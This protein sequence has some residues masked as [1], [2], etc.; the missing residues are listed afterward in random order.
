MNG[1]SSDSRSVFWF[2]D[3]IPSIYPLFERDANGNI[4]KDSDYNQ[5][6]YDYGN[7]ILEDSDY[8]VML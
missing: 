1:Q 7:T 6:Q 4:L 5:N 3:N 8:L 2:V